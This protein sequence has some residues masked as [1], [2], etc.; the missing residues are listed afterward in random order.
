MA[1]NELDEAELRRLLRPRTRPPVP[2]VKGLQ[3][4]M[5]GVDYE[6][7]GRVLRERF[8]TILFYEL[9]EPEVG[10]K[11][12]KKITSLAHAQTVDGLIPPPDW[13]VEELPADD[14]R[15]R[16]IRLCFT[17]WRL[18][19]A[20]TVELESGHRIEYLRNCAMYANYMR[21]DVDTARFLGRVW[22][23]SEKITTKLVKEV[24]GAGHTLN[25]ERRYERFGFDALR[26]CQQD[27]I[28]RLGEHYR[29][30]DDWTMP[31]SPYYD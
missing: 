11:Y 3:W 24:D 5:T 20:Y 6:A 23:A 13:N 8:P 17:F 19:R 25:V 7:L 28:R 2:A 9:I 21:S 26:W 30:T 1:E 12:W 31:H 16:Q 22:R 15:M 18:P 4:Y 29:P 27:P 14:L 10:P